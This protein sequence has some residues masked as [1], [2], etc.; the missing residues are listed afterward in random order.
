MAARLLDFKGDFKGG[1]MPPPERNAVIDPLPLPLS[2]LLQI[3]GNDLREVLHG[4]A[5]AQFHNSGN[6]CTLLVERGAE[7][8]ILVGGLNGVHMGMGLL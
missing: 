3:N 6:I 4:K 1:Q 2:L 5:V 8:R 7:Q